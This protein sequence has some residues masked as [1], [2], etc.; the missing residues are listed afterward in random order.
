MMEFSRLASAML[1]AS[2]ASSFSPLCAQVWVDRSPGAPVVELVINPTNSDHLI[3][4]RS[5]NGLLE[6]VESL[7][8]GGLWFPLALPSA[9]HQENG[10]T[11]GPDGELFLH[12]G[13][14][15]AP[16]VGET[17]LFRRASNGTWNPFGPVVQSGTAYWADNLRVGQAN[18][19][20][21]AVVMVEEGSFEYGLDNFLYLSD[22]G[23]ASWSAST[24]GFGE[25]QVLEILEPPSG[26]RLVRF[27]SFEPK[28]GTET[29]GKYSLDWSAP[30][31]QLFDPNFGQSQTFYS[32]PTLTVARHAPD[33]MWLGTRWYYNHPSDNAP[34]HHSLDGGQTWTPVGAPGHY[35][36]LL[37]G[38][39]DTDLLVRYAGAGGLQVSKDAGQNWSVWNSP[40]PESLYLFELVKSRDDA[41]LYAFGQIGLFE[42]NLLD[43]VGTTGCLAQANGSGQG[44]SLSAHG[45]TSLTANDLTLWTQSTLPSRFGMFFVGRNPGLVQNPGGSFGDLCLTGPIGRFSFSISNSGPFGELF[46]EVDLTQIPLPV[47]SAVGQVGETWHFQTWFRD[48]VGGQNGTNFSSSLSLTLTP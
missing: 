43:P 42:T 35:S 30:S 39:V 40:D 7:D 9:Q 38:E 44:A 36:S 41:R 23:G 46:Q 29:F 37:R 17:Y 11:F 18:P 28:T 3:A 22:D 45:S 12:I 5:N 6:L 34:L 25:S 48:Q 47:G 10:V 13:R 27:D 19:D 4:T 24:P 31:L 32:I 26:P 15:T 21:M 16:L 1:V 8:G 14:H 20:L 2:L 33:D